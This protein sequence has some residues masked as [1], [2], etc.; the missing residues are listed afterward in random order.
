MTSD[1]YLGN[2]ENPPPKSLQKM[3]NNSCVRLR[4]MISYLE[5]RVQAGCDEVELRVVAL[6]SQS[7]RGFDCVIVLRAFQRE[8]AAM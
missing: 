2:F 4:F 3:K 1:M 6:R 7:P 8:Y 5:G